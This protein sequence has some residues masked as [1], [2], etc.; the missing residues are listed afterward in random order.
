MANKSDL[1]RN[2]WMLKGKLAKNG[3]DWWWHSFTGV[4]DQTGE[5]KS[6]FIEFFA[7]N[8]SCASNEPV[9]VWNDPQKNQDGIK[10]S[11]LMIKVGFWG[12]ENAQLHRF[13]SL[14]DVVI[15]KG[16]PFSIKA[17]DCFLSETYT[18]GHVTVTNEDVSLHPERMSDSGSMSW[19][20][21]INKQIAFNVGYGANSFF[22]EINAFEMFWHAEGMK[23]AFSGEVIINDVKYRIEPQTCNGYADKNWG[24]NFTSPWVWLSSNHLYRLSNYEKLQNSVFDIGGGC[25]K[26]YGIPLKRKLLGELYLE[27][28]EYEFNFSKFW[29]LSSTKMKCFETKDHLCFHIIQKN[30]NYR[31]ETKVLCKKEEMLYVNY[32]SPDGRK[33][34]N[35]LYNGGT[36]KGILKLYKRNYFG[37]DELLETIYAKE[38]GCEYGIYDN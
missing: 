37:K 13:F 7:C 38:I 32:E 19:N 4:N 9:I 35:H 8:P 11:Y 16:I 34:Y 22:R 27:G 24:S 15:E 18:K 5:R 20:L 36:G 17:D 29:T 21:K 28:K 26:V 30:K 14:K 23:T 31:L 3:Y 10:P 2:Q 6:F 25:P 1:S 33:R 12:K